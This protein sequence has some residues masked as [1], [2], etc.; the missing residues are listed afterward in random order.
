MIWVATAL[1]MI[2]ALIALAIIVGRVVMYRR[3]R[4][5]PLLLFALGHLYYLS[6]AGIIHRF[7][8]LPSFNGVY[9]ILDRVGPGRQLLFSVWSLGFLLVFIVGTWVGGLR[10]VRPGPPP[11]PRAYLAP[12]TAMLVVAYGL[13]LLICVQFRSTI[14]GGYRSN[15]LLKIQNDLGRG[16]ISAGATAVALL[17]LLHLHLTTSSPTR[18]GRSILTSPLAHVAALIPLIMV[19]LLAGGRLYA[20]TFVIAGAV[21]WTTRFRGIRRVVAVGA[22]LLGLLGL[23]LFGAVRTGQPPTTAQ[24]TDYAAAESVLVSV[25]E[26]L[27]LTSEKAVFAPLRV[28]RYLATDFVNA[29]PR[30]VL[31]NK[32][33]LQANPEDDGFRVDSPL[34]GVSVSTSLLVNFGSLGSLAFVGLLA[35]GIRRLRAYAMARPEGLRTIA[36]AVAAAALPMSFFRDKFSVSIVRWMVL[37]AVV[38]LL[39]CYA[40]VALATRPMRRRATTTRAINTA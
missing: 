27:F 36:Y 7:R 21:W 33:D 30:V 40:V 31:P 37:T 4:I 17:I 23:T 3:L 29:V 13:F 34:G 25:S 39:V 12:S 11:E 18:P 2:A 20:T 8:L 28:P 24:M 32:D 14:L 19:L 35:Y 5:E 16:A 22:A 1:D 6:L 15:D 38:Q 26:G 9:S 10:P